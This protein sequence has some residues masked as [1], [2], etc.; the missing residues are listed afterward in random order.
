M[1]ESDYA[2]CEELFEDSVPSSS[3]EEV[4]RTIS[5][6]YNIIDPVMLRTMEDWNYFLNGIV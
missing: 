4:K 5:Q 6:D 1:P 3:F 2:T